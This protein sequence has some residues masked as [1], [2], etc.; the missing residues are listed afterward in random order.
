M[1]K[2]KLLKSVKV[3]RVVF[4]KDWD[5]SFDLSFL[6]KTELQ[7]MTSRHTSI[8]INRKTHNKEEDLDIENLRKEMCERCVHG[9]HGV[10]YR[11]LQ[12]IMP[13]DVSEVENLDEEIEFSQETLMQ[14]IENSYDLD[15]WIFETVKDIAKMK[16]EAVDA[17]IKN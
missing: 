17:E 9:W 12:T 8:K 7:K 13:I 3:D 2:L 16:E 14:V 10:T 6:N 15:G 4:D 5:V 1:G 11:Y